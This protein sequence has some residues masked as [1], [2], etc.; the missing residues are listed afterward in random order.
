MFL[1]LV[2]AW[3]SACLAHWIFTMKYW[4]LSRRI[5]EVFTEQKDS[6]FETK[7]KILF[8]CEIIWIYLAAMV[9]YYLEYTWFINKGKKSF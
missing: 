8:W 6:N 7:T 4:V 9:S 5:K 3:S 2:F 1:Y